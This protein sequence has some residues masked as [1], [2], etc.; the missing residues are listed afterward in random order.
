[1]RIV[2]LIFNYLFWTILSLLLGIAYMRLLLGANT[3]SEEGLGYLLHL[4]FT[5]G[6]FQVGLY[7]GG[8]IALCFILLDV[9]YFRKKLKNNPKKQIIRLAIL[10]AITVFVAL[11][12]YILEK[13]VDVI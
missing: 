10:L 13:V 7:V 9:F 12:H 11:V 6:M 4:F 2:K 1:M 3:V 5:I 8:A